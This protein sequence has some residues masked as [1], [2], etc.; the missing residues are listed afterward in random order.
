M[1]DRERQK[2]LENFI[3]FEQNVFED[4]RY[5]FFL[6]LIDIFGLTHISFPD[7]HNNR[8]LKLTLEAAPSLL[9]S[10]TGIKDPQSQIQE[11]YCF[12]KEFASSCGC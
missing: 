7:Y 2:G 3:C 6:A 5:R 12:I 11:F 9:C 8:K 10:D 4:D 1:C